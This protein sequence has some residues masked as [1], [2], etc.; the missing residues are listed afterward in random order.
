[1]RL[2]TTVEVSAIRKR[3]NPPQTVGEPTTR[4]SPTSP[5]PFDAATHQ[6]RVP[7]NHRGV[8]Y[9]RSDECDK[10]IADFTEAIRLD[11][12]VAVAYYNRGRCRAQ[13][14]ECAKAIA[15]LT[16]A[17]RLNPKEAGNYSW[18]ADVLRRDGRTRQGHR[19]LHRGHPARSEKGGC[20]LRSGSM[21]CDKRGTRQGHRRLQRGHPTRPRQRRRITGG[22]VGVSPVRAN[23]TRPLPTSRRPS[24]S[25]DR[26]QAVLKRANTLRSWPISPRPSDSIRKWRRITLGEG[27]FYAGKFEYDRAIGE[28][29]EAIRLDPTVADYYYERA[30]C[31]AQMADYEDR[32]CAA[33]RKAIADCTQAIR[34][35]PNKWRFGTS[36]ERST[37]L[38]RANTTRPSP[39][40]PRSSGSAVLGW[41]TPTNIEV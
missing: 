8:C 30:N 15:D 16:E 4:L 9:F 27:R 26:C 1:M 5:M 6:R 17:I 13:E 38:E 12:N 14:G 19:R 33:L 36:I 10:A 22:G 40:T 35:D 28:F 24:G 25:T 18:R 29:S 39:I 41:Q 20:V 37:T 23:A 32:T 11:R 21:P 7:Y 3:A 2:P 34:L 31:Y